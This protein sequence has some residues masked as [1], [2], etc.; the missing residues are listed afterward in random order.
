MLIDASTAGHIWA[1]RFDC[2][3]SDLFE[4]QDEITRRIA[5]AISPRLVMAE[6]ARHTENPDALDYLFRARSAGW[7]PPSR[8]KYAE[9]IDLLERALALDPIS[10]EAR[11][12]LA[13]ALTSRAI[14]GMSASGATDIARADGL[15]RQALDASSRSPLAHFAKGQVLRAQRRFEQAI[16]EYE[17]AIA[18]NRNF[19][20]ALHPLGQCKLFTGYI[21]ETIP[22][23]EQAIRLSPRDPELLGVWYSQIG[24]VH[25]LQSR[26]EEAIIWLER[27]RGATPERPD[28][29][30]N[31]AS[32]YAL[33]GKLDDAA[34]E[35]AEARRLSADSR[36]KSKGD[37]DGGGGSM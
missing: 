25:L 33:T 36:Y 17:T 8:Q 26:S 6:A 18:G 11:S 23:E 9:Q 27:A 4:V 7:R 2:E 12:F 22:L 24:Q 19:V 1:D 20:G 10:V 16:P 37:G 30:A 31:L 32:A 14:S 15:A 21:E 5:I 28:V 35:F 29:H 34:A 13:I 3:M